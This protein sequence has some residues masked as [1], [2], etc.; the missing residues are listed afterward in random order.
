MHHRSP[1]HL[2]PQ[3]P[4]EGRLPR[5]CSRSIPISQTPW[6]IMHPSAWKVNS[7]KFALRDEQVRAVSCTLVRP[8][9]LRPLCVARD[10]HRCE[11]DYPWWGGHNVVRNACLRHPPCSSHRLLL[12]GSEF[13]WLLAPVLR[14]A[15]SRTP[16]SV[17]RIA[18]SCGYHG[19]SR[20]LFAAE[21][22]PR[23]C[24]SIHRCYKL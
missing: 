16:K 12:V 18:P 15:P 5:D 6:S 23:S 10:F 14:F 1:P 21:E 8:F 20:H 11:H 9:D 24:I 22:H 3:T 7:A 4:L 13:P 17:G 19:E 2:Q